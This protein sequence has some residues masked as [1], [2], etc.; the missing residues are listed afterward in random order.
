[1]R[2]R[3]EWTEKEIWP[4]PLVTGNDLIAMRFAPGPQFR[5]ILTRVE[6]EQLNGVLTTRAE[7][8]QFVRRHFGST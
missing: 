1:L 7:A 5:E 2:K 3:R 6:D 4:V 8:I